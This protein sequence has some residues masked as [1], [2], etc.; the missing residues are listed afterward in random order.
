MHS[1]RPAASSSLS[2]PAL[3]QGTA[4]AP[5]KPSPASNSARED[6]AVVV[7]DFRKE[8]D[9]FVAVE[10][11]TFT[12]PSGHILGL[13]GPNGAGKTTTLRFLATLLQPT[14]GEA[15]VLGVSIRQDPMSVRRLIGYMP[16]SF[17]LYDGMRVW[18]YLDFFAAA[19]QLPRRHRAR[20]IDDVLELLDLTVKRDDFVHGLSRGMRQRLGLARALL[21]DPPVLILD[22]PSSG[23]DPRAR[24]EMKELV[25]ELQR[26]GK[27]IV[28]S[29]HILSELADLC[30]SVAIM[31]RGQLVLSGTLSEIRQQLMERRLIDL[32]VSG[33]AQRAV[34]VL[35]HFPGVLR[36]TASGE[37]LLVE[38]SGDD[39]EFAHLLAALVG[40]G[41]PVVGFWE[42]EL[43]LEEIFLRVTKGLVA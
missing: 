21:H 2:T 32:K 18:E 24:L 27:T 13:I 7:Q 41:V 17:G 34:R 23:L 26:M 37:E 15:W 28:I 39:R 3:M 31:E 22:E 19:Y 25:R 40:Q 42:R 8:Y 33:D 1:E 30:T 14:S 16:E 6:P 9:G 35:E 20:V 12:V 29:S 36:V 4:A 11:L 38:F 10:G 5:G 43:T